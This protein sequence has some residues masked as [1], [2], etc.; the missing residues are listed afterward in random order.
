MR[1]WELVPPPQESYTRHRANCY[2][3]H[4]AKNIDDGAPIAVNLS[5]AQCQDACSADRACECVVHDPKGLITK[6]GAAG[7]CWRRGQCVAE[8]CITSGQAAD[9]DTYFKE[10]P[11]APRAAGSKLVPRV[12]DGDKPV[13][14]VSLDEARAYCKHAGKRLPH[15]WEWQLAAQGTDGRLYPWGSDDEPA[16]YPTSHNGNTVPGPDHVSA[17]PGGASPFGA[18][19][20]VGNVWQYTVRFLR[21]PLPLD[22]RV[23]TS[24]PRVR[25]TSSRTTTRA[26]SSC[27]AAAT[28]A[29]PDRA[30]TSRTRGSST[31]MRNTSSW[32][33]AQREPNPQSLSPARAAC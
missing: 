29:R 27:A 4:G 9:I 17:H 25:R 6:A 13:T 32:T 3:S 22:P 1:N 2:A 5:A 14:Y 12:G 24:A 26:R 23:S 30:G 33:H 18:E 8:Y 21:R 28:T 10:T 31:R 19:D 16:N 7:G 20:M 11:L 15:V